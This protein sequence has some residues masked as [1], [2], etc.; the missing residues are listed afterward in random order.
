MEK[1]K[2][3]LVIQRIWRISRKC[4][5]CSYSFNH[6]KC[7]RCPGC[8]IYNND[9]FPCSIECNTWFPPMFT[10]YEDYDD[11]LYETWLRK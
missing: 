5:K 9:G 8:N 11:N 10:N 6:C 1:S 2:A 4:E 7:L 3:T